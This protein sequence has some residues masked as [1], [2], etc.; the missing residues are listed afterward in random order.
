KIATDGK[1]STIA[2]TGDPGFSGDGNVG[3]AAQLYFPDSIARDSAG[4]LYVVDQ[5]QLRVRKI[6]PAGIISTVAG[7]GFA[8]L[9]N[10]ARGAL[11]SG[12][13]YIPGIAVDSSGN[14]YLSEQLYNKIKKIVPTGG[15]TTYA[16][17]SGLGFGGDGG[18][19]TSAVLAYPGALTI[20]GSN[21]YI[22]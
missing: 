21:L 5:N 18:Q 17:T 13:A 4:N 3:T 15:M 7:N 19:A 10:D 6:T 1:I 16:G 12:F 9:S 11:G 2:G 20:D 22:A 14:M 8:Q